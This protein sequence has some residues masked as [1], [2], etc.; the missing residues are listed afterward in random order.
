MNI[1]FIN[2]C[3]RKNSNTKMLATYLLS[4]LRGNVRERD[5]TKTVIPPFTEEMVIQRS[6]LINQGDFSNPLFALA[7]EFAAAD[8]IVMA[9]P[10]WDLSFP[11]LLKIY[12]EHINAIGVTFGYQADGKPYGLCKAQKLY[13]VTTAGGPIFNDSYGYGYVRALAEQFYGIPNIYCLKAENLD[14]D[15]ADVEH[16][17]LQTKRDIDNLLAQESDF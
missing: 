11:S 8:T 1:L 7:K 10:L 17:L 16:I 15:G 3:P 9:A 12:M 13:Y 14:V 5:L 4:K 2:A 6:A